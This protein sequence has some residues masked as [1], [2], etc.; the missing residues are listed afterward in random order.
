[1]TL[2]IEFIEDNES[3]GL[4]NCPPSPSFKCIPEWYKKMPL[5]SYNEEFAKKNKLP[6]VKCCPFSKDPNIPNTSLK[7]CTPF[8]D[9]ISTGYT[10]YF[11]FDVQFRKIDESIHANHRLWNVGELN[12]TISTHS[13]DQ[14]KSLPPLNSINENP[15]VFKFSSGYR[16]KTPKGYS[17]FFTHPINR[18]E[19]P[20]ITYSGVVDSDKYLSQVNFPFQINYNF[21]DENDILI[22][23][24]GTPMVN[25][26][27]F[28]REN[29][30][31]ETI[32]YSSKIKDKFYFNYFSKI[33][34]AYKELCW[35]KKT[36]I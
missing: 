18:Y 30:K 31:M 2:K 3:I 33:I 7:N 12:K 6:F 21:K 4:F 26:F 20:F 14:V 10:I 27:P 16:V 1:M 29:W 22:I 9:A 36:Y 28:K 11:P 24:K 19:L 5:L 8:L 35:T 25:I 13:I 34:N 23:E 15:L 17:T 32:K